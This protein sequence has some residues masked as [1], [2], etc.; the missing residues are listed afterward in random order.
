[1]NWK[2][3]FTTFGL[4]FLAELGDKTQLMTMALSA[5]SR[6]PLSVFLGAAVA[7]VLSSLIGVLVGGLLVRYVPA[8]YIRLGS[9]V[10]FMVV[11]ALLVFGRT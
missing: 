5:Q 3:L 4:V 1:M 11:G 7:L 6:S 10:L 2:V 8:Q 9:G